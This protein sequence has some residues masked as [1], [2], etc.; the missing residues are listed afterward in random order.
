LVT[1]QGTI[2]AAAQ[3]KT[4]AITGN[5]TNAGTVEARNGGT[6]SIQSSTNLASNT[7]TGGAWA[8]YA[9]STMLTNSKTFT[10]NAANV[11]LDGANSVFAAIAPISS[12]TGTFAIDH[13]RNFTTV[14]PL[15]NAG[16]LLVGQSS[17]LTVTGA[18]TNTGQIE[19]LG[20]ITSNVNSS[21]TVA[22]GESPGLL[23]IN[24]NFTQ[25]ADGI[26]DIQIAGPTPGTGY[27]V[28]KVTGSASLAGTLR[29]TLL[30][31]Y[32]PPNGLEFDFLQAASRSGNF[33][34][35]I[36]PP[37]VQWDTTALASGQITAVP[38][39]A[40]ALLLPIA[41]LYVRRRRA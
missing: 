13:G 41:M 33:S 9:G 27:D 21:G 17:T 30:N 3:G 7:L 20:I 15:S 36:L 11:T 14:G 40:L 38:E 23:T 4:L 31:G 32:V 2:S 18:L 26:L 19:G 5:F 35:V 16:T 1:N 25:T 12:N 8:I 29:L 10:T 34:Q 39:P 22:P 24:G 6:L 37:G 28:L